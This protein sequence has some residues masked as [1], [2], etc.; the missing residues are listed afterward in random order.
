MEPG[1]LMI[2]ALIEDRMA[3]LPKAR[4]NLIADDIFLHD[5]FFCK[6][7]PIENDE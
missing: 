5:V 3:V 2:K 1:I 6:C 4:R 7:Y